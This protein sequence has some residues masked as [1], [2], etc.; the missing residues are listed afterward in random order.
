MAMKSGGGVGI[1]D[2]T[3]NTRQDDRAVGVRQFESYLQRR[4]IIQQ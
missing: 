1:S 4:Q 3:S 2:S